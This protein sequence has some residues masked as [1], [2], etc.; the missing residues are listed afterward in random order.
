MTLS[1][2]LVTQCRRPLL[3]YF[4]QIVNESLTRPVEHGFLGFRLAPG[5][6]F[7]AKIPVTRQFCAQ[8]VNFHPC[9][10]A[11]ST[12]ILESQGDIDGQRLSQGVRHER[13]L[14]FRGSVGC[15]HSG[16]SKNDLPE[17]GHDPGL[18]SKRAN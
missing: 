2:E 10:P 7:P 15:D 9:P 11:R 14:K 8:K 13:Y 16:S 18:R 6:T 3:S 12:S 4:A 17:P 1:P 5:N